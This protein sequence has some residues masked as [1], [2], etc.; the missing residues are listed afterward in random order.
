MKWTIIFCALIRHYVSENG[1]GPRRIQNV[2]MIV[3]VL[4]HPT[5]SRQSHNSSYY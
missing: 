1:A 4:S 2:S 5:Y 3:G